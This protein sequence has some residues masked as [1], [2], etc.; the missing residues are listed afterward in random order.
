M[1]VSAARF[2]S[3]RA[4]QPLVR[5]RSLPL[6]LTLSGT[7]L[8]AGAAAARAQTL[9]CKS[10]VACDTSGKCAEFSGVVPGP[11]MI[12]RAP[13]NGPAALERAGKSLP[14]RPLS[15]LG[16]GKVISFRNNDDDKRLTLFFATPDAS[17]GPGIW[18]FELGEPAPN[19]GRQT[20]IGYCD[21]DD[22]VAVS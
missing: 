22:N 11:A 4:A 10:E 15:Q 21:T 5:G 17:Q 13:A 7:V 9:Y 1:P 19:G 12:L 3:P 8:V 18:H 6:A 2:H 14:L 20:M 16:D